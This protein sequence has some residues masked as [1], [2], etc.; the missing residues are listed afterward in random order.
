VRVHPAV[1][2]GIADACARGEFL[3]RLS[4]TALKELKK[5]NPNDPFI[6]RMIGR[7]HEKLGDKDKAIAEKK[8]AT[9]SLLSANSGV[10][11]RCFWK[12]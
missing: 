4:E 11:K 3:Q 6:Q 8:A 2:D 9:F 12:R 1:A 5:A 10:A 7:A